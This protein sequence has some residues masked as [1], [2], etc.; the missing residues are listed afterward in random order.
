MER[1]TFEAGLRRTNRNAGLLAVAALALAGAFA[2]V[3]APAVRASRSGLHDAS[4]AELVLAARPAAAPA[5]VRIH[6][7][8]QLKLGE[9]WEQREHETHRRVTAVYLLARVGDHA[10]LVKAR[11][12]AEKARSFAG[13]FHP[14]PADVH[15]ELVAPLW[16]DEPEI[17]RML[18]PAMLDTEDQ[19]GGEVVL[20][21]AA[22]ALAGLA[23][24]WLVLVLRRSSDPS[25]HPSARA[26]ARYGDVQERMRDLEAD[27]LES[28]GG[29]RVGPAR[30]GSRWLLFEG[31]LRCDALPVREIVWAYKRI[32][33][34]YV[35][36][37]IPAGKKLFAVVQDPRG[38]KLEARGKERDVDTL[39]GEIVQRCPW[40]V[41]G[42][43]RELHKAMGGKQRQA[44]VAE[45]LARRDGASRRT[46]CAQASGSSIPSARGSS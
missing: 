7:D 9:S 8:A 3:M 27:L 16:K 12:G 39:L 25:R 24:G 19:L 26:L 28:G 32:V 20:F 22:L 11:A 10:L 23:A 4:E 21:W 2:W 45:I 15:R 44:L 17:A 40:A 42:Y 14:V 35:Y 37:V 29:R 31:W 34:Q 46:T 5:L 43:S 41:V 33:K 18:L 36:H 6:P 30:F 1:A 38:R 13:S